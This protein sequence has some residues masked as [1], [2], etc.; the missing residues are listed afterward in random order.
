MSEWKV[1]YAVKTAWFFKLPCDII[2]AGYQ[3][4]R[5]VSEM[6]LSI[7][8]PLELPVECDRYAKIVDMSIRPIAWTF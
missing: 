4:L 5:L 8:G 2:D 1:N 7:V 6:E 3:D